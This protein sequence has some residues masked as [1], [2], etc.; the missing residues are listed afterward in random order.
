MVDPP[1]LLRDGDTFRPAKPVQRVAVEDRY[2]N[3][4]LDAD[5]SNQADSMHVAVTT[6]LI[7]RS[8]GHDQ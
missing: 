2:G 3:S 6:V 7:M 8:T 5:W 1:V 4:A